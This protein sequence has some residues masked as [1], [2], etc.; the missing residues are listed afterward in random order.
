MDNY[1]IGLIAAVRRTTN[2]VI[3]NRRGSRLA[4]FHRI[5][6]L[7]A[8]AVLTVVATQRRAGL[9]TGRG[10]ATLDT[11]THIAVIA[12]KRRASYATA[13]GTRLGAVADIAVTAVAVSKAL[14]A[15][16]GRLVAQT[17]GAWI[18]SG[19]AVV[20]CIAGLAA[21]AELAVIAG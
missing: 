1:V 12:D 15:T 7:E 5:A 4:A 13:V 8:V 11:V 3:N 20:H 14:D 21:V 17:A 19:L 9:T 10:I 18:G 2:S 16:V 6:R